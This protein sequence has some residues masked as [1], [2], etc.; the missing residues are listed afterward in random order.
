MRLLPYMAAKSASPRADRAI[1]RLAA[2]QHGVVTRTQ[3]LGL[4]LK[5][6][7]IGD[8]IR[9]GR[10]HRVHRGVYSVGHPLLTTHG[11]YMAAVLACGEGAV[12]SH[13]SAARLWGMPWHESA[14]V[15]VTVPG[16]GGRRNRGPVIVHRGRFA[17]AEVT[18]KDGIPVTSPGRTLVD[19]ADYGRQR[20]LKR[21][22]DEAQ[23]LKLDLGSLAPR[24]GRHA[25]ALLRQMLDQHEPGSTRTRSQLE[26]LFLAL[27]EEHGVPLPEVNADVEGE[28]V[29]FVWRSRRL[30]IETDGF[31]SHGTRRGFERDRLKDAK[32]VEAGWRV[33]RLTRRRVVGQ[34]E[35]VAAQVLRLLHAG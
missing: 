27:R 13:G 5:S 6:T 34:P 3:L 29:D 4:G 30:A 15:D 7:T 24:P 11:R 9:A 18:T 28:E 20:A 32:L 35:A 1:A 25:S 14:R 8:R 31:A 10:L 23:H 2:R 26:E 16:T 19:L 12:L 33:V 17:D 21:A 22:W